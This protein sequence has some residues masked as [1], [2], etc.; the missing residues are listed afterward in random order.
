M[1]KKDLLAGWL[2]GLVWFSLVGREII[3]TWRPQSKSIFFAEKIYKAM[4]TTK[5]FKISLNIR[6]YNIS[7]GFNLNDHPSG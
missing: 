5:R 1:K 4:E 2:V 6:V 3:S 7:A